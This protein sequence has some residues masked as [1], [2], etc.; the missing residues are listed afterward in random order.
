MNASSIKK[1]ELFKVPPRWVFLKITTEDGLSGWGEPSLEGKAHT[2]M[3]AVEEMKRDLISRDANRI[4]DIFQVLYRASFYRGGPVLMSAIAGIEQALWDL[5]GK[6]LGVPVYDLLGG[7]VRDTVKIYAWV[8]GDQP[9]DVAEAAK[10]RIKAGYQAVKMNAVPKVGWIES[11]AKVAEIVNTAAQVREAVGWDVGIGLDFHGRV[12][13]AM[14]KTLFKELEPVKPMFI[15]EPLLPENFEALPMIA[16]VSSIPIATGERLYSRWDF[17][18]ILEQRV[19]DIIQPDL[20]HA[21]GIWETRKIAAMAEAYDVAIAPHCPL[22]PIAFA[23]CL[24]LQ[25]CTPNGLIQESSMGIHYNAGEID[26]LDYLDNPEDF[27]L[28]DGSIKR[29]QRPGLGLVINEAKVR[30]Q[31]AIGHDWHNPVWRTKDGGLAEW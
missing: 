6:R 29:T 17:K 8:G 21:G 4:E 9:K 3:A 20:S 19:V 26:L 14:A 10:A 24:Q 15:E 16:A 5:K 30:E 12:R 31:A 25:F 23:S 1:I 7:P 18:P 2:V 27:S 11:P 28:Q 13:K 22:G